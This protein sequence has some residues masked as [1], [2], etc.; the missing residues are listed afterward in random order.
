MLKIE[1]MSDYLR[2][3]GHSSANEW[4]FLPEEA[5]EGG[6]G[7]AGPDHIWICNWICN[8]TGRFRLYSVPDQAMHA[9][10]DLETPLSRSLRLPSR[11]GRHLYLLQPVGKESRL[12]RGDP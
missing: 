1:S 5:P 11:N 6:F 4:L 8:R 7:V 10:L 12:R 3:S 9:E 2:V